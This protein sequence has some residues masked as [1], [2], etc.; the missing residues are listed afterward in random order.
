MSSCRT[1]VILVGAVPAACE[2]LPH[3][4][5]RESERNMARTMTDDLADPAHGLVGSEM[6]GT[7]RLFC[8]V[9]KL[10]VSALRSGT[11]APLEPRR[12][13]DQSSRGRRQNAPA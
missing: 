5:I 4:R 11:S 12:H 7:S 10:G 8:T 2:R 13:K 3:A 1:P 9:R 6:S